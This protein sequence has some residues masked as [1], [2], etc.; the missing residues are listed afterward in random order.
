MSL[1]MYSKNVVVSHI[2]TLLVKKKTFTRCHSSA[3]YCFGFLKTLTLIFERLGCCVMG[4][5]FY[6]YLLIILFCSQGQN[7]FFDYD[8]L[9]F[10]NICSW[11]MFLFYFSVLPTYA[12]FVYLPRGRW[13]MAEGR[14][15]TLQ[16]QLVLTWEMR[17]IICLCACPL[18]LLYWSRQDL[19]CV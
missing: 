6:N 8:S 10:D 13:T 17:M 7:Y 9:S 5:L 15:A 3:G 12:Y 16:G 1:K 18:T 19:H 14:L 2:K 4:L 11:I